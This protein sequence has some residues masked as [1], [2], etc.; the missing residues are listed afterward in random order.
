[1]N[2]VNDNIFKIDGFFA[3]KN[4]TDLQFMQDK[5]SESAWKRCFSMPKVRKVSDSKML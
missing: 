5:D 1:M 3:W 4:G 2:V